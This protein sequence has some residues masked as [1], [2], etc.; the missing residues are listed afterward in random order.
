[1]FSYFHT[2]NLCFSNMRFGHNSIKHNTT[3][4]IIQN[5]HMLDQWTIDFMSKSTG[6]SSQ[7]LAN[8]QVILHKGW[9]VPYKHQGHVCPQQSFIMTSPFVA[10]YYLQQSNG[11]YIYIWW[12]WWQEQV[13]KAGIS[14][15]IPQNTVVCNYLSL[16]EIPSPHIQ[17]IPANMHNILWC[18]LDEFWC[19]RYTTHKLVLIIH[20]LIVGTTN[21]WS[22]QHLRTH[23]NFQFTGN[24]LW[25]LMDPVHKM[26]THVES[27]YG[28]LRLIWDHYGCIP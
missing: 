5:S 14:N 21:S 1:M 10:C 6:K 7:L 18:N 22:G 16:P 2:R 28:T 20:N 25:W 8:A 24:Q 17:N 4:S 15:C 27:T 13:S 11:I 19:H 12:C 23:Q 9:I 26:A 3:L